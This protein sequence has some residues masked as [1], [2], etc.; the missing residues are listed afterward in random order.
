M[1]NSCSSWPVV[2]SV[3][4]KWRCIIW[5]ILTAQFKWNYPPN[6]Q[7]QLFSPT[8]TNAS[9]NSVKRAYNINKQ[10]K[11][12]S[13]LLELYCTAIGNVK[14]AKIPSVGKNIK[15]LELSYII[16]R[17]GKWFSHFGKQLTVPRKL[18]TEIP[19]DLAIPLLA[20]H[21]WEL[22]TGS[23]KNVYMDVYKSIKILQK[24][25]QP[26]NWQKT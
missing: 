25:K 16:G 9:E 8:N 15:K 18:N 24:W 4:W 13:K 20:I 6:G 2:T 26:I 1:G 10:Q 12:P 23:H 7:V 5:W 21:P 11:N 14:R 3:S 22:K 17:N 19:Y